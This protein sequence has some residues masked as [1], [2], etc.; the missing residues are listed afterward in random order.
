QPFRGADQL[1]VA[2][3]DL[4]PLLPAGGETGG[5]QVGGPVVVGVHVG[6]DVDA[7][8]AGLRQQGQGFG[9]GEGAP[10]PVEVADVD[11]RPRCPGVVQ[12]FFQGV[13]VVA[14][15]AVHGG[16]AQVANGGHAVAGGH[17]HQA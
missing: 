13:E 8:P 16:V 7:F 3:V 1:Q 5:A 6:G 15:V 12:H 17:F 4:E 10:G 2:V 14:P 11:G 9:H